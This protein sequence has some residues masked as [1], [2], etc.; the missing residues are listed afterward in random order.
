MRGKTLIFAM[1]LG[2]S[3]ADADASLIKIVEHPL[4]TPD[5]EKGQITFNLER[6][7][8][9]SLIPGASYDFSVR[10][11]TPGSPEDVEVTYFNGTV[12]VEDS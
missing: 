5:G 12:S 10:I 7:E 3:L 11:V 8:T 9:A 6:S 4:S 1:K 2:A